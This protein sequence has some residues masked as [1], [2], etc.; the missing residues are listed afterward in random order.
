[1]SDQNTWSVNCKSLHKTDL[2][3]QAIELALNPGAFI[4]DRACFSFVG[5][6]D[7]VEAKIARLV[8]SDPSRAVALYGTF[9]AACYS[10]VG[11][12]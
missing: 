3:E 2:I 6:L 10:K 5:D 12:R 9:L 8:T 1:M 4:S 7:K 11:T